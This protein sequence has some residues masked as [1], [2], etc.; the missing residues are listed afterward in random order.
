[1]VGV[2]ERRREGG[3]GNFGKQVLKYVNVVIGVNF[4]I[5]C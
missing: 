3:R 5:I 2:R 4:K 1:M